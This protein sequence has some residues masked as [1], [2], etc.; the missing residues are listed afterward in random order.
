MTT[1]SRSERFILGELGWGKIQTYPLE[2]L[3]ER[4]CCCGLC[5]EEKNLLR[6]PRI[7]PLYQI[8]PIYRLVTLPEEPFRFPSQTTS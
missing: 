3:G 1:A 2:K 8:R 7:E 6:A 4:Q 5:A